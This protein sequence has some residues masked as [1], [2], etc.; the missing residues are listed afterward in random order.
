MTTTKVI[1]GKTFTTHVE[2]PVG[3][4]KRLTPGEEAFVRSLIREALARDAGKIK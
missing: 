4:E 1:K 3:Y 2:V